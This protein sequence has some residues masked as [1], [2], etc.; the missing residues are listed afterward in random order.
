M[1]ISMIKGPENTKV[2]I[3]V[4][5]P[6]NGKYILF[7]LTRKKIKVSNIQSEILENNIGYIR[8]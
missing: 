5:R 8:I 2:S 1:I 7:N 3:Y 6:S 4:Y